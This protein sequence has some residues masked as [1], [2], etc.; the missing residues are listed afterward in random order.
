MIKINYAEVF[1][2]NIFKIIGKNGNLIV[3]T[4]SYSFFKSEKYINNITKSEMGI[5]SEWIRKQK[6][7]NEVMIQIFQYLV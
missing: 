4:F 3:P 2:K 1:L 7:V 6:I 5:F